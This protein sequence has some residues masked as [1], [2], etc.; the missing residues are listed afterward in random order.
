MFYQK[1]LIVKLIP[2]LL[3]SDHCYLEFYVEI[4]PL[5]IHSFNG[6]VHFHKLISLFLITDSKCKF[7]HIHCI[8]FS[9]SRY[10]QEIGYTDTI[11]DVRSNRVRSLL[12]LNNN[13]EA[14]E[15][16]NNAGGSINGNDGTN[17]RTSENQGRQTPAK[18][19]TYLIFYF[20]ISY[21]F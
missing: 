11:I 2:I 20:C 4:I 7:I 13:A 16:L 18:K 3:Q 17:K 9:L 21:R 8:D 12:G 14:E 10:L 15:N 1:L 5:Q 6:C 19:V